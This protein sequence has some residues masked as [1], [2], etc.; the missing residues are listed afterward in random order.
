MGVEIW[1]LR[2]IRVYARE[3]GAVVGFEVSPFSKIISSSYTP[4]LEASCIS[5]FLL[6]STDPRLDLTS[7][8]TG[9]CWARGIWASEFEKGLEVGPLPTL[10]LVP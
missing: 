8:L 10:W 4:V 9:E 7:V 1:G 6:P 5:F 3:L 2:T